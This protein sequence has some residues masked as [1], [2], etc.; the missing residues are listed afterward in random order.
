MSEYRDDI[1][2]DMNAHSYVNLRQHIL[3][4]HREVW[5]DHPPTTPEASVDLMKLYVRHNSPKPHWEKEQQSLLRRLRGVYGVGPRAD[6]NGVTPEFGHRQMAVLSPIHTEA[7]AMIEK[8]IAEVESLKNDS[9]TARKHCESAQRMTE[10]P[11][12]EHVPAL[13][14]AWDEIQKAIEVL[15]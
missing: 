3:A 6:E 8:L 5:P 11:A 13:C 7:A 4:A 12:A 15:P 1:L 10:V 2:R 9:L 14:D